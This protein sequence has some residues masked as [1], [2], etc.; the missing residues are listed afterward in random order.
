M[1]KRWSTFLRL[2]A[3]RFAGVRGTSGDGPALAEAA[4]GSAPQEVVGREAPHA[5]QVFATTGAGDR[6][7]NSARRQPIGEIARQ[8][9]FADC[10]QMR[11]DVAFNGAFDLDIAGRLDVSNYDKV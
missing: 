6:D 2:S 1:S 4:G 11:S 5:E 9:A 10:Q 7:P 3:E 8:S